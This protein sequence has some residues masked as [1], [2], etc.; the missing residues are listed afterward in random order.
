MKARANGPLTTHHDTKVI[1]KSITNSEAI[2]VQGSGPPFFDTKEGLYC[3][4]YRV[5]AVVNC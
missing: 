4:P 3:S 5:D 2:P 1:Q